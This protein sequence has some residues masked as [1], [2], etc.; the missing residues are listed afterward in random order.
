M[1]ALAVCVLMLTQHLSFL[2]SPSHSI[3]NG[4]GMIQIGMTDGRAR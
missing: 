3:L 2:V 1:L 4:D